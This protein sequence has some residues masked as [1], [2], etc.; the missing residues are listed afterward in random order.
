MTFALY[1][2][3]VFKDDYLGATE[4]TLSELLQHKSKI[5]YYH[6]L[7]KRPDHRVAGYIGI[8]TE[9]DD[10][11]VKENLTHIREKEEVATG[12]KE[13]CMKCAPGKCLCPTS[14]PTQVIADASKP[15]NGLLTITVVDAKDLNSPQYGKKDPYCKV[16]IPG[17]LLDDTFKKIGRAVQQECRDRSRMPSSA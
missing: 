2:Q 10:H 8:V 13:Q 1:D 9:F 12:Q 15:V 3:D 5:Q 6:L 11:E 4:V 7:E 17:I 16:T 14:I